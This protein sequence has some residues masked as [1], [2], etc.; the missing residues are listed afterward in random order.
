MAGDSCG[1]VL[2]VKS[3]SFM[4][5]GGGGWTTVGGGAGGGTE[6]AADGA[7]EEEEEVFRVPVDVAGAEMVFTPGGPL[8]FF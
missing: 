8:G 4:A 3:Y 2:P 5:E 6:A 7:E 1:G